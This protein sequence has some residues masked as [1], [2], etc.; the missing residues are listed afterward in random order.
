M[1]R[2]SLKGGIWLVLMLVP[3]L[4]VPTK[5]VA[6]TA[7][8]PV[9]S[10][11]GLI[12]E[13]ALAVLDSSGIPSI[14]V[15]LVHDHDVVWT[16]AYGL[17]NVAGAGPAST[18]TYYSTGSTFKAITATAVMQLVER[19]LVT[20][21]TPINSVLGSHGIEGAEDVSL[22]HLLGHHSGLDGPLER[23]PV[24]TR[25]LPISLEE[26]LSRTR[27]V[28]R[29]GTEYRYCNV[30]YGILEYAIEQ[31]SGTPYDEYVAVNI[32]APLGIDLASAAVPSPQVAE[33][34][35]VPYMVE[36]RVAQAVDR[37][38]YSARGAGDAY[39]RPGDMARL[40]AAQ[41]NG[42]Q[43]RGKRI[44]Q[45]SS[46][47]EMQRA[48]F[49]GTNGL[50]L[51]VRE[52]RGHRVFHSGGT[53]PGFKSVMIGDPEI[54]AGIYVM[55]NATQAERPINLLAWYVMMMLWGEDVTLPGQ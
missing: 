21:D 15:A 25:A 55:S 30:C 18:D 16:G 36:G 12:D 44:L 7:G 35:A 11:T 37:V 53:V 52:L 13:W 8:P 46:V 43:F 54:G 19:G 22:R 24:W 49:D 5:A 28:G 51:L 41:L 27:A 4:G 45:A 10:I 42:G 23:V 32:L 14:S 29:P 39:L 34:L 40:V 26:T 9:D 20:L 47:V 6:Q 2:C 33:R 48:Q 17:A 50:G 38:R 1:R 3:A 31:L